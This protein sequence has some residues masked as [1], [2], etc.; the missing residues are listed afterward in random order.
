[1]SW[2]RA[3]LFNVCLPSV[4]G[5]RTLPAIH[6]KLRFPAATSTSLLHDSQSSCE[7]FTFGRQ[8]A[9][10]STIIG[11]ARFHARFL[12]YFSCN[13]MQ[14]ACLCVPR[15]GFFSPRNVFLLAALS[16]IVS[17]GQDVC[18]VEFLCRSARHVQA[19]PL[20]CTQLFILCQLQ[21]AGFLACPF[22]HC[23]L[24]GC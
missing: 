13:L 18:C 19:Q 21:A 11:K 24:L 6:L 3:S 7:Y 10:P 17:E 22:L 20:C 9:G 4:S 12:N 5:N 8:S 14:C 16:I 1:M 23:E 15:C 2:I